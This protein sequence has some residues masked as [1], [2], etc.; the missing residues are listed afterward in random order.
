MMHACY[1]EPVHLQMKLAWMN[2]IV[3]LVVNIN[4]RKENRFVW[5]VSL[6]NFQKE[7]HSFVSDVLP[8]RTRT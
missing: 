3:V 4:F 2:V 6:V 1:V 8:G 7:G 5:I